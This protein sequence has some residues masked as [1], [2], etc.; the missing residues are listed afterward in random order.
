M[1]PKHRW[2]I[3]RFITVPA[4][5]WN[6]RK[7]RV[8]YMN[9]LGQHLGFRKK[10]DW[11]KLKHRDIEENYGGS[12]VYLFYHGSPYEA[13][14][15][16]FPDYEWQAWKFTQVPKGFWQ[17][18][19]NRIK[20]MDWLGKQLGFRQPEDW[21]RLKKAD[22]DRN[23]GVGLL[24]DF[25]GSPMAVV[26]DVFPKRV[27]YEWKFHQVPKGFWDNRENRIRYLKWLGRQLGFRKLDG[28]YQ[29]TREDIRNHHGQSLLKRFR[30]V[31]AIVRDA[32]PD[33]SWSD[34][35]FVS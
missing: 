15:D 11:Y 9:W 17:D 16:C 5:F 23:H 3:W 22:F 14:K 29:V 4:G 26:K 13:V 30:K 24:G 10:E 31:G 12:V 21:Y 19:K 33:H 2:Q 18:K 35:R 6:E 8:S 20:Y 34:D 25:G 1:F 32:F 27:W 7:N 28:W